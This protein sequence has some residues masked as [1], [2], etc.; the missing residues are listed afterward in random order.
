[1]YLCWVTFICSPDTLSAFSVQEINLSGSHKHSCTPWLWSGAGNGQPWQ[2]RLEGE[3]KW[4]QNTFPLA[5]SLQAHFLLTGGHSFSRESDSSKTRFLGY[6]AIRY[7]VPLPEFHSLAVSKPFS[8]FPVSN[9]LPVSCGNADW[10]HDITCFP[11]L[12]ILMGD[13][14]QYSC[15]NI[16]PN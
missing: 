7:D 9:V 4:N 12:K 8:N 13:L 16:Y 6:C 10:H 2:K 14:E 15:E 11:D 3:R 5:P 1:M